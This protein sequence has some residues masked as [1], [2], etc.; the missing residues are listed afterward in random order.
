MRS[1]VRDLKAYVCVRSCV[2][3]CECVSESL[4]VCVCVCL[5]VCMCV[6]V[7]ACTVERV[8]CEDICSLIFYSSVVVYIVYII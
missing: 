1:H 6:G 2:C 5:C 8:N 3:M 7:C 4:C